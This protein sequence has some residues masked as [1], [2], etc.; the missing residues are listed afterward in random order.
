MTQS[1]H[2]NP[3]WYDL[4]T[5][6]GALP[7]AEAFYAEVLGWSFE[8]T[9][10]EALDF[11]LAMKGGVPVAGLAVLDESAAERLPF[12]LTYFAVADIDAFVAK[13]TSAGA[14][15][16][17][18]PADMP[19]GLRFALLR[20]PQNAGFGVI[21]QAIGTMSDEEIADASRTGAFDRNKAG[22]GQWHE[23]MSSD[24]DG[25]FRFYSAMLDW[26]AGYAMPM[27]MLGNYQL[28]RRGDQEIGAI[29]GLGKQSVSSWLPYFG[30]DGRV[31]ERA[32]TIRAAGG[33]VHHGPVEVPGGIFIVIAQDPQGAW[34]AIVG[35]LD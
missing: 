19:G 25:A 15:I 34:F 22:H 23:L 26:T 27:G 11:R 13:A 28:I 5:F 4:A 21:E 9:G 35:P 8:D 1:F 32:Q 7:A 16:E 18:P 6:K 12:W 20:D 17:S 3:C 24:P 30:V 10:V 29:M 31:S 14:T 2:G 33:T